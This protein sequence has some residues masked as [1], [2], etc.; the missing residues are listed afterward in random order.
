[1]SEARLADLIDELTARLQIGEVIDE[2]AELRRHPEHAEELRGL[3]PALRMLVDMSDPAAPVAA[4]RAAPLGGTLGDFR[5]LREVGRGGMGVVY[6]AEQISLGRR[7]A[8]KVL[9][10]AATLDPR[11]LQRFQNEARAAASLRHEHIVPV[12]AVGSERGLHYYAMQFIDGRSLAE[13]IRAMVAGDPTADDRA[14]TLASARTS[15]HIRHAAELGAQAAAALEHAHALGIVHRD[16]KPANLM[17]DGAGQLWITDFGL[18][19][20]ANEQN[21]TLTGDIVGTLRYMSPEQALAKHGLVDHRADVYG[22]A[23]TLYELLTLQP[24]IA[25]NDREEILR[26]VAFEEPPPPRRLNSALP[27]ELETIVLKAMAKEP[28]HRYQS[29]E[30]FADDLRRFLADQPI[31]ARRASASRK[32]GRWARRNPALSA[33]ALALLV[34][35]TVGNALVAWKWRGERVARRQAEN[36]R[37]QLRDDFERLGAANARVESALAHTRGGRWSRAEAEFNAALVLR[38]DHS[39]ALKERGELYCRLGLWS[40]ALA[41]ISAAAALE[42]ESDDPLPAFRLGCLYALAG[43]DA[44]YRRVSSR[45]LETVDMRRPSVAQWWSVRLATMT[46]AAPESAVR[47][48][49]L[50]RAYREANPNS[51]DAICGLGEACFAAGDYGQAALH[52]SEVEK[53]RRDPITAL[54]QALT[55]MRLARPTEAAAALRRADDM[56]DRWILHG[57]EPPPTCPTPHWQEWAAIQLLLPRARAALDQP[58]GDARIALTRARSSMLLGRRDAAEADYARALQWATSESSVRLKGFHAFTDNGDWPRA[59][60]ELTAALRLQPTDVRVSLIAARHY[61]GR[62][63]LKR[64]EKFAEDAATLEPTN[65]APRVQ[66]FAIFASGRHWAAADRQLAAA[67]ALRPD[68]AQLRLTRFRH[69]AERG[70]WFDADTEFARVVRARPTDDRVRSECGLFHLQR[71]EWKRAEAQFDATL[72]LQPSNAEQ[73]NNRGL[74]RR[75]L[76]RWQ[77]AEGDFTAAI[78]RNENVAYYWINRGMVRGEQG[79]FAEAAG[80]FERGLRIDPKPVW[81]WRTLALFHLAAGEHGKYEGVCAQMMGRYDRST[82]P[83]VN[84]SVAFTCSARAGGVS[85]PLQLLRFT[86]RMPGNARDADYLWIL[87]RVLLR[88]GQHEAAIRRQQEAAGIAGSM[89]EFDQFFL[90]M[91]QV[92]LGNAEEARRLFRTCWNGAERA[93][94]GFRYVLHHRLFL[95]AL[96]EETEALLGK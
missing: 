41:D 83:L 71:Q 6:E 1:M 24:A 44:N 57:D 9:P 7:V 8:L 22:L 5:L 2:S 96:R 30:E 53:K 62:G 50:A 17:T 91:A 26:R 92:R 82:D 18:A 52:F 32:L 23:V 36:A 59:E 16:I 89:S 28:R 37:Q 46:G 75:N 55:W 39:F 76:E 42:P 70:D 94:D 48:L 86:E 49:Q 10:L 58:P 79:H 65:P 31:Q 35:F 64:A 27:R 88:A 51:N 87:S 72:R 25:G 73:W 40:D 67:V 33:M 69:H 12:F 20:T 93:P 66:A 43:D 34:V 54:Y 19:R 21:L 56:L 90:V 47:L 68:D 81:D 85:D 84:R 3:F 13:T 60:A 15:N 77:E 11:H 61:A 4:P 95:R 63:D 38:P 45:F 74:C 78:E 29:A 80:D 14:T